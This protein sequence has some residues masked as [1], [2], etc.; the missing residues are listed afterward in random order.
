[1]VNIYKTK[2]TAYNSVGPCLSLER[3]YMQ[4][5]EQQTSERPVHLERRLRPAKSINEL[6]Q[7]LTRIE[8]TKRDFTVPVDRLSMNDA[9]KIVFENGQAHEY[10]LN[11][12]SGGQVAA[13]TDIPREYFK[14][15]HLEA[16][17]LLAKNVN[18]GF[19]RL[20]KD[21][22]NKSR[23]V[24]T[25]DGHVRGFLSHRYLMLDGHDILEAAL[26]MLVDHNFQVVSSEIT[27]RR[28]YLK[29]ATERIQGEVKQGDVVSYGVMISSSDVGAGSIRIEPFFLRLWCLNGAVMESKF[30]RAHLGRSTSERE[31]QEIMSAKTKTLANQA[32]LGT[33]RDYMEHTMRPEVFQNELNKMKNA[34]NR[35]IKNLNLEEVVE[36]TMSTVGITGKGIR[37][38]ILAA[39]ADGNQNAGLT[40][41]GLVNSFTAAAKMPSID[42]DTAT[43]LERAGGEILNLNKDQWRRI[44]EV[45]H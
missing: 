23:L 14:R 10:G 6:A 17:E 31:V 40:Q 42:Y 44:A 24:R 34:A 21:D 45:S 41:W 29:T 38:G 12:W 22:E 43:D 4:A 20:I 39:L 26:P 33:I 8:K 32:L 16:P 37:D 19:K 25:L 28:L 36:V 30:R 5:Q 27:E 2:A 3:P 13:Y 11:N 35:E 7:E 1:M 9:G 15:L 18:H